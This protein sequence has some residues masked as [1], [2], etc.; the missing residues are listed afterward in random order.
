MIKR[1]FKN[2]IVVS[3]RSRQRSITIGTLYN[4]NLE[5]NCVI[6]EECVYFSILAN[7][8]RKCD[9]AGVRFE[10]SLGIVEFEINLY[11][12]RHWDYDKNTWSK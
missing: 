8:T 10:L 12:S 3:S 7:W 6:P 2:F 9:H 4:K 5:I 11:D 1:L